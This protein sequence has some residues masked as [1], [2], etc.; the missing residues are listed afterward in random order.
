MLEELFL[1]DDVS[2]V[3]ALLGRIEERID[4][5]R[6]LCNRDRCQ[7]GLVNGDSRCVTQGAGMRAEVNDHHQCNHNKCKNKK[8][9][10]TA[11][12]PS[13]LGAKVHLHI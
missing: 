3:R 6:G 11:C 10:D 5:D 1:I 13:R 8:S 2:F 9:R 12:P 4:A 7:R